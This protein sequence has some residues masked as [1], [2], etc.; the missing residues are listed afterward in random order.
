[1]KK[2]IV[3][4]FDEGNY[5]DEAMHK[6]LENTITT[7]FSYLEPDF[8]LCVNV[9]IVSQE[10]IR[11]LNRDN[12][13][14]DKVTDVLSFPMLEW[15]EPEKLLHEISQYDYDPDTKCVFLGDIILCKQRIEEQAKEY[16]H[17]LLRES[18]YLTL[19]GVLHLMGYDHMVDEDK[20]IM[21]NKEEEI[22]KIL[23]SERK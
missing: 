17:S 10:E 7:A 20:K 8:D 22:L 2:Y 23:G 6:S 14:V 4:L 12:R 13:D 11:E 5:Y 1:M 9:S 19:H 18:V 21:R 3:E 16:G 15:R